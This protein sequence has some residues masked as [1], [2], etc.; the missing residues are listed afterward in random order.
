MVRL[1]RNFLK[2]AILFLSGVSM[3]GLWGQEP[4]GARALEGANPLNQILWEYRL[5]GFSREAYQTAV[6]KLFESFE[7][8]RGYK[9]SPGEK[10]SVGLKVYTNSGPGI[11]TPIPLVQAVIG[12]LLNRGYRREDLFIV[13][14]EEANLRNAGYI[15]A[16]SERRKT[17]EGVSVYALDTGEYYDSAWYYDNPLPSDRLENQMRGA[18]N[19]YDL[20]EVDTLLKRYTARD[21]KSYLPVP[22]LLD[23]DFWINLPM[24]MDHPSLGISGALA[25]PTIWNISNNRRFLLNPATAPAAV[26]EIAAIPELKEKWIFTMLTLERYQFIGGPKFRSLYTRTEPRLLLSTNPVVLDFLML[27][28]I[29]RARRDNG[30][31]MLLQEQPLFYYAETLGLGKFDPEEIERRIQGGSSL[32]SVDE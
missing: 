21:R 8:E 12:E 32:E 25:N 11:S 16:L 20:E 24:A 13:D 26:T 22:L 28:K 4:A 5:K 10:R 9:M 30:F 1:K 3:V 27:E 15:P 23:V 31:D 14:L 7:T 6:S 17:F 29:N 19:L 18:N 2:K